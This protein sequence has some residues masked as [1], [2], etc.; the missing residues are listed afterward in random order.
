M[1]G[2]GI[3]MNISKVKHELK[4]SGKEI[5][6]IYEDGE[7]ADDLFRFFGEGADHI[8]HILGLPKIPHETELFQVRVNS[9][10]NLET[11]EK[12]VYFNDCQLCPSDDG[13]EPQHHF[14]NLPLPPIM[15]LCIFL[16]LM[17]QNNGRCTFG[18]RSFV[19]QIRSKCSPNAVSLYEITV[20]DGTTPL[21][22]QEARVKTEEKN[23]LWI[24][25]G[26]SSIPHEAENLANKKLDVLTC[27]TEEV[28]NPRD[29]YSCERLTQEQL[30]TLLGI[31]IIENHG[32][33]KKRLG[34]VKDLLSST[35]EVELE[36]TD[37][38]ISSPESFSNLGLD[39]LVAVGIIGEK[40]YSYCKFIPKLRSERTISIVSE[41]WNT[42]R[43]NVAS[44][45]ADKNSLTVFTA[46]AL[47]SNLDQNFLDDFLDKLSTKSYTVL[48][49][50]GNYE[51]EQH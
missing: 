29:S 27:L 34:E 33:N 5:L 17:G 4:P 43:R 11:G 7:A 31:P 13:D 20:L 14:M 41:K 21:F 30:G 38:V 45:L 23:E 44:T 35:F 46:E 25:A 22:K 48:R 42:R 19:Y 8:L 24:R 18:N 36:D 49:E 1:I 32:E 12:T 26:K 16:F 39:R 47:P 15:G 10:E 37:I 51:R 3:N 40:I 6:R 9:S 2:K 28:V 50:L